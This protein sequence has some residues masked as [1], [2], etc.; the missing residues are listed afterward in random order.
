L[1]EGSAM[2]VISDYR[3]QHAKEQRIVRQSMYV[4]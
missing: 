3:K 2:Q 4:E 1:H